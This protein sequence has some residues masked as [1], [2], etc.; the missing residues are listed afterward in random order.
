MD[1]KTGGRGANRRFIFLLN[2]A[3]R[4][5]QQWGRRG[6]E[7]VTAAQSGVLFVIKREG[8]TMTEV[9][10]TLGVGAPGL[11]GLID[12]M[13]AAGLVRRVPDPRD[14]RVALLLLTETGL[15]ARE[16]AKRRAAEINARL[17]EGFSDEEL[18]VVAR[19]LTSVGDRFN[20]ESDA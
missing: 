3:Q 7:P 20:V 9:S 14:G 6:D 16:T 5:V 4:R 19:W 2:L 8:S 18:D 11:S 1:P 15:A 13:E 10:R 17:S 12:R